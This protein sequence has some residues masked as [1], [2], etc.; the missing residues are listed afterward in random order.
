MPLRPASASV[1]SPRCAGRR[2]LKGQGGSR[3]APV[4]GSRHAVVLGLFQSPAGPSSTRCTSCR[5]TRRG[6]RRG[7][8]KRR[9]T[10]GRASTRCCTR[11]TSTS[12]TG[13]AGRGRGSHGAQLARTPLPSGDLPAAGRPP[14]SSRGQSLRMAG[15][16]EL[17]A[18]GGRGRGAAVLGPLLPGLW[19]RGPVC[20]PFPPLCALCRP[21][22]PERP[23]DPVESDGGRGFFAGS[24]ESITGRSPERSLFP[25]SGAG[26][27]G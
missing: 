3:A 20:V 7:P 18:P 4:S 12:T 22:F 24:Q 15:G 13:A 23:P 9:W 25:E 10:S 14:S 27:S 16:S 5:A 26:V 17:R 8:G 21:Q 2:G 11:R 19:P 6:G 1:S